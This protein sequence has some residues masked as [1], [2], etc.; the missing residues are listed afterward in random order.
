MTI[1]RFESG[2]RMSHAVVHGGVV[3]LAGQV[4]TPGADVTTQT[5]DVLDKIDRL[6]AQAGTD[7]SHLLQATIWLTDMADFAAMN[8]VWEEWIGGANAPARATGEVKLASPDY[9]V[10]VIVTAAMPA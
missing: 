10:E 6:L 3:Y 1:K 5:R 9:K 4:G 8:V 7:R 2:A